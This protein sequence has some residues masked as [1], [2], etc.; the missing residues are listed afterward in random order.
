M[1]ILRKLA[2]C[3]PEGKLRLTSDALNEIRWEAL[4]EIESI[5]DGVGR[6]RMYLQYADFCNETFLDEEARDY[7]ELVL[8]ETVCNG[9][10]V[11]KYR[12]LAEYAYRKYAGLTSSDDDY[13]WETVSQRIEQYR[14]LFEKKIDK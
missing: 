5:D 14:H 12:E 4:D 6:L 11:E 2:E 8:E 10:I 7:Y 3:T 9:V 1:R 13:V